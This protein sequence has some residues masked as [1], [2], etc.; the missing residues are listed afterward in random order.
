MI[1]AVGL[2]SFMATSG[3]SDTAPK[4][5]TEGNS[6]APIRVIVSILPQVYFVQRIGESNIEVT[7]LVGPGQSHEVYEPTPKQMANLSSADV[8]FTIGANFEAS[9]VEKA[10]GI[11]PSLHIIDTRAGI[12]LL[13]MSEQDANDEHGHAAGTPDPHIWL[14]PLAVK[15]Q[16]SA[17]AGALI[18][19]DPN[20]TGHYEK[21]LALFLKDLDELHNQIL[22]LLSPYAG[23]TIF[24][25]HPAFGYFTDRYHLRQKA[26]EVEGKEPGGKQL[27]GLIAT[28]KQNKVQAVFIQPQFSGKTAAAIAHEIGA[29]VVPIN[30]LPE[31][32]L[33]DMKSL[34]ET[35]ARGLATE[36]NKDHD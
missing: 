21:N 10:R 36:G 14:D 25:F 1:L 34:A 31:N 18:R 28:A 26:I 6:A 3:L 20:H 33:T 9:L 8:Y 35:I 12:P 27:A 11:D 19:L 32:Y 4:L 24:V 23:R 5:D 22:A 15:T 17:I 30:P 13:M 2:L 29:R 7:C 16:A